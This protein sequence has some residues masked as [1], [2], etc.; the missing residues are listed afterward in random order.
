MAPRTPRPVPPSRLT[1]LAAVTQVIESADRPL[2]TREIHRAAEELAGQP[3]L[4]TSVKAALAAGA[5]G[6]RPRFR[7]VRHGIYLSASESNPLTDRPLE[8]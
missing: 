8:N 3:L 4:P 1:V 7:R 2:P 5:S 6:R